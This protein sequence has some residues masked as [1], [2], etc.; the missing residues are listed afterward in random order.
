MRLLSTLLSS[1]VVHS[2]CAHHI[3]LVDTNKEHYIVIN[4]NKM[5]GEVE[6][7][8]SKVKPL[9][10]FTAFVFPLVLYIAQTTTS[11]T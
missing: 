8:H 1:M 4:V 6:E 2:H 3:D 5:G 10:Y 11:T 7:I 9:I